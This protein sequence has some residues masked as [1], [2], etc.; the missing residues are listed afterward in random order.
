MKISELTGSSAINRA[1]QI[2]VAISG[3]NRSLTLG[4]IIDALA[5][6]V[7]PFA[8]IN[9]AAYDVESMGMGQTVEA[10]PIVFDNRATHKN[11]Y[12]LKVTTRIVA[13]V[14]R[15]TAIFYTNFP[16]REKF[17]D[18][19]G[20]RTD[21]LF[22]ATDGRLYRYNG[23]DLISAGITDEQA[24]QLKLLTPIPVESEAALE[25]LEKAGEIVPGQMYYIPEND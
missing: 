11:F 15:R 23:T 24:Q 13:G 4:Q 21:C 14:I 5:S 20:I 2:P 1:M 8:R 22:I 10:L 9:S 17:Y 3:E 6:S 19:N 16:N 25:A 18:D 7:V 12:A